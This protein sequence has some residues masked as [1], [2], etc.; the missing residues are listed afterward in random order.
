MSQEW[1]MLQSEHVPI[2]GHL[3]V[4]WDRKYHQLVTLLPELLMF[5]CQWKSYEVYTIIC[6]TRLY[7]GNW[8]F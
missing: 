3:I 6:G 7:V 8:L 2:T 5:T 4:M 1:E